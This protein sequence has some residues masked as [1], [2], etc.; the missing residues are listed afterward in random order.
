VGGGLLFP[1]PVL[2]LQPNNA[3]ENER[4]MKATADLIARSLALG[5]E[6]P[7]RF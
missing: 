5:T 7:Q 4:E 6:T 3:I 2:L 1:P